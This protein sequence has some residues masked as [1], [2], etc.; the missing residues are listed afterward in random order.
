MFQ[1]VS[2]LYEVVP[3]VLGKIGKIKNPW[4]N[5]DAHSGVLLQHYDIKE[6]NFYTVLF[7]VSRGIGVLSHVRAG[8]GWAVCGGE[9][10]LECAASVSCHT[11]VRG[12]GWAVWGGGGSGVRPLL[13]LS[14]RSCVVAATLLLCGG[15]GSVLCFVRLRPC[16]HGL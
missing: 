13:F 12:S 14:T 7:G 16:C 6:E 15:V 8:Q 1:L 4:P 10:A 2:D 3:E 9:G 11:C 5:V